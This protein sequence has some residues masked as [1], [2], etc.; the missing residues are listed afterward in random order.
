[1]TMR[2]YKSTVRKAHEAYTALLAAG[3]AA[4]LSEYGARQTI[5][6]ALDPMQEA[7][8][9]LRTQVCGRCSSHGYFKNPDGPGERQCLHPDVPFYDLSTGQIWGN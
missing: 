2:T 1:M 3:E 5:T 4:R 8:N 9:V 6:R 7:V